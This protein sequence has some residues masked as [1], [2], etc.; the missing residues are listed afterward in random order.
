MKD[1][2]NW[3]CTVGYKHKIRVFINS[4]EDKVKLK[5]RLHNRRTVGECDV[6]CPYDLKFF[7]YEF[8]D[9][10]ENK[11]VAKLNE[12]KIKLESTCH[13]CSNRKCIEERDM[14]NDEND[15]DYEESEIESFISFGLI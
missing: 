11:Q 3:F 12:I 13:D 6:T 1:R 10:M 7:L 5:L 2:M 9:H 4:R 8:S 14:K 15:N